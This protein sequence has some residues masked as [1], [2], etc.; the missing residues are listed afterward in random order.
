M[1]KSLITI[2][3]SFNLALQ[4]FTKQIQEEQ[5][6]NYIKGI[7]FNQKSIRRY[8]TK[9]GVEIIIANPKDVF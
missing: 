5:N 2:L 9:E 7:T 3:D 8:F 6:E 1:I 4:S